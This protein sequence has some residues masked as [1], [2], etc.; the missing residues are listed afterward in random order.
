MGQNVSIDSGVISCFHR[1]NNFERVF[2]L[3]SLT[4]PP[5]FPL[6]S[7]FIDSCFLCRIQICEASIFQNIKCGASSFL[8]KQETV[9]WGDC[10]LCP[11]D[12][13][14]RQESRQLIPWEFGNLL[15]PLLGHID[16]HLQGLNV[17]IYRKDPRESLIHLSPPGGQGRI[18]HSQG[19]IAANHFAESK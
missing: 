7:F 10:P 17:G 14:A 5:K 4:C 6:L 3:E 8:G 13:K 9:F 1:N 11:L 15:S 19:L 16:A 12:T 2:F 18:H